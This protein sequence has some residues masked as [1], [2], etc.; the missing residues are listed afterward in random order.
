MTSNLVEHR[1]SNDLHRW[2]IVASG[3]MV[4]VR[5]LVL[6]TMLPM[7]LLVLIATSTI[8]EELDNNIT[9]LRP[10][11]TLN[12]VPAANSLAN[13]ARAG[14]R[15]AREYPMQP[16]LIPHPIDDYALD[17]N[18]NK[19]MFCH[20]RVK[21]DTMNA[22]TVTVTHYMDRDGNFLAELSPRRYFCTQCHVTQTSVEPPVSN[23]Y[24][25]ALQLIQRRA[26]ET[27]Q[28]K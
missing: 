20:S 11:A 13:T 2:L 15:Q 14:R 24:E 6:I 22:P 7:I 9:S 16:P 27:R 28:S 19:C 25:N 8:A 3:K 12:D 23:L 1:C 10:G 5:H 18:A 26:P 4:S 17:R 21:S